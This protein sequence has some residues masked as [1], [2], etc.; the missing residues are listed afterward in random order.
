MY[1]AGSLSG[2]EAIKSNDGGLDTSGFEECHVILSLS[3]RSQHTSDGHDVR[4]LAQIAVPHL[5]DDGSGAYL[6]FGGV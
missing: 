3:F 6:S 1:R 2:D 4:M 5:L